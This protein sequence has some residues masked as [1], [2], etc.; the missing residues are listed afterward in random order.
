MEESLL[1]SQ[2]AEKFD[3]DHSTVLRWIEKNH[4]PNARLVETPTINYWE[5]PA[6]DLKGFEPPSRGPKKKAR[7]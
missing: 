2:I 3:R 1:V 6:S 4:F 7:I 5:V